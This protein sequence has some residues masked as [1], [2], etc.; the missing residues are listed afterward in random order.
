MSEG[1]QGAL[2]NTFNTNSNPDPDPPATIF[3]RLGNDNG[4]ILLQKLSISRHEGSYDVYN[5]KQDLKTY[6][7]EK[8]KK[9]KSLFMKE[10]VSR[11]C[12][13][14][15]VMKKLQAALDKG[16]IITHIIPPENVPSK[17]KMNLDAFPKSLH[18]KIR[19]ACGIPD[20]RASIDTPSIL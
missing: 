7:N 2:E 15:F 19:D 6:S 13:Y 4:D 3:M 1:N 11:D 17:I 10:D 12:D 8:I 18:A 16:A 14:Q 20:L 9:D 5:L